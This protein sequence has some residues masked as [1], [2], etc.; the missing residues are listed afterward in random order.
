MKLHKLTTQKDFETVK[1]IFYQIFIIKESEYDLSHFKD[2]ITGK[3]NLQR[4]EYYLGYENDM[5]VGITGVYAD[6]E[7]ECW[8]GWF[9]ITPQHR[10]KGYATK[11]LDLQLL[12]MKNY[13]YKIC[14]L[15]TNTTL[16][17][18]AIPM[19]LKIGFVKDS[20]YKNHFIT[21]A[22]SLDGVTHI[23]KWKGKPLGFV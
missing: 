10:R 11:M 18:E 5:A 12:M 21:M 4:L 7:N 17:K 16:N 6:N 9:G 2:S 15:Y 20:D 23:Q 1:S 22:K 3:H 19:Y 8:L 13:G 14:R